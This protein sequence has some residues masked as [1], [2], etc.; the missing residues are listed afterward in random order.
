MVSNKWFT[1][2]LPL[3]GL[4]IVGYLVGGQFEVY[5]MR[6]VAGLPTGVVAYFA[7]RWWGSWIVE[8]RE[9]TNAGK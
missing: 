5:W 8:K 2:V 6:L 3:L 7:F 9:E 1:K 4:V